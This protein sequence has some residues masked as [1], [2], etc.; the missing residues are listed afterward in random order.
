MTARSDR[1]RRLCALLRSANGLISYDR[2]E[3]DMG[4]PI[5]ALRRVLGAARHYL[6]RDE[7]I[8]FATERGVG[9]RRMD[10]RAKVQSAAQFQQALRRTA[11]RGLRRL[12][13]IHDLTRLSPAD[14]LE[15]TL[16]R[17]VFE[18]V[19]STAQ[20]DTQETPQ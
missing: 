4:E 8:V 6:E 15:A 11:G 1:T 16:R 2:L 17:R 3:A 7:G 18:T 9:L 14:Q 5:A 13:T 12:D 10:D 19:Q 20:A